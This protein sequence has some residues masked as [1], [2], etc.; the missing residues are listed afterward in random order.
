MSQL[1]QMREQGTI[2]ETD[3]GL[4]T[5]EFPVSCSGESYLMNNG[6]NLPT[7]GGEKC[8]KSS[9]CREGVQDC[10]GAS[11]KRYRPSAQK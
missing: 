5:F 10:R 1:K 3:E 6:L 9:Q 8:Q 2:N 11:K 7:L 4:G